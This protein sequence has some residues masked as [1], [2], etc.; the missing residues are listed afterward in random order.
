MI[1]FATLLNPGTLER[2]LRPCLRANKKDVLA[3]SSLDLEE[4][5]CKYLAKSQRNHFKE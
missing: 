1:I 5:C 2:K 3:G 4:M